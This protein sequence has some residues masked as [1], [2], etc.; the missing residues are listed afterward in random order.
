MLACEL[1]ALVI[2]DG[3]LVVVGDALVVVLLLVLD[4]GTVVIFDVKIWSVNWE[5][6]D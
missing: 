5:V 1:A 3:M 2:V 6:P 4:V